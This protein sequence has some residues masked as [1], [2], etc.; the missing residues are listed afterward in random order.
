MFFDSESEQN[1]ITELYYY[2]I[3]C[4]DIVVSGENGVYGVTLTV[5]HKDSSKSAL[6]NVLSCQ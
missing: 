2:N 3:V 5:R 1:I 6:P 4:R